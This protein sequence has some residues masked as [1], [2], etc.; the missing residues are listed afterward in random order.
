MSILKSPWMDAQGKARR[1]WGAAVLA[2]SASLSACAHPVV[3]TPGPGYGH[4]GPVVL[5]YGYAVPPAPL[6]ARPAVV[7]QRPVAVPVYPSYTSYPSYNGQHWHDARAW[8][9]G[10]APGRPEH[11]KRGERGERGD[12]RGWGYG[13]PGR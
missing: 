7:V 5:P 9:R 4:S 11:G 10:D 8:G 13:H 3:V 6:W 2:V 1:V 12:P